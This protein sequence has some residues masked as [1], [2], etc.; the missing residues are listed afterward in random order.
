MKTKTQYLQAC[1][2]MLL[3]CY[4]MAK[5]RKGPSLLTCY[6]SYYCYYMGKWRARGGS[7]ISLYR[8]PNSSYFTSN[9]SNT[10]NKSI[11]AGPPAVTTWESRLVTL[12]TNQQRRDCLAEVMA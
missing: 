9:T 1:Y 11:T 10:S 7:H 4:Y 8:F 3:G 12:V 6:Y 5:K 2:Y